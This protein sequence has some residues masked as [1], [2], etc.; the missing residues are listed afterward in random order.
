MALI[1]ETLKKSSSTLFDLFGPDWWN[2]SSPAVGGHGR[3]SGGCTIYGQPSLSTNT[4]FMEKGGRICGSFIGE[5]LV[6]DVYFPTKSR[7]P[8]KGH[9]TEISSFVDEI[10]VEVAALTAGTCSHKA[11]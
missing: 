11:S 9:I 1:Q 10:I 4:S 2:I 3:G 5:G 7:I 6:L 8:R